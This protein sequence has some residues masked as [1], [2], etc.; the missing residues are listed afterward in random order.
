MRLRVQPA[1]IAIPEDNPFKFDRLNRQE[2]IEAL[3]T[4]LGN[5]EGPCVI[6][7]DAPW[8]AGK[9]TFIR[10][11]EQV[12]RNKDIPV[13]RVNAWQTDFSGNPFLAI[14][15]GIR[16]G[17]SK[18]HGTDEI[19]PVETF[20]HR[21]K[22]V[23]RWAAPGLAQ[24]LGGTI[25]FA[26]A[27]LGPLLGGLVRDVLSDQSK[28]EESVFEFRDSLRSLAFKLVENSDAK[29]LFIFID[30]L[31]RCRPTYAVELLE[32]DK[33]FFA[34]DNV[35][36]V[37]S[38]NLHQL[39]HSLKTVYGKGFDAAG[40]LGRFFDV[41]YRLPNPDKAGFI[42]DLI[43]A[44]NLSNYLAIA[45]KPHRELLEPKAVA[46]IMA[47]IFENSNLE[48][49]DID[50]AIRRLG[51]VFLSL[52]RIDMPSVLFAMVALI[53]RTI[54][55]ELYDQFK[56][57]RADDEQVVNSLLAGP[58]G[59]RL[60]H[61]TEAAWIQATTILAGLELAQA[62]GATGPVTNTPLF[63]RYRSTLTQGPTSNSESA[64]IQ[65]IMRDVHYVLRRGD[66]VS[67]DQSYDARGL[68]AI[69]A[70]KKV[71][72]VSSEFIGAF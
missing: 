18:Y 11:W 61:L 32:V 19:D 15:S 33:H 3:T 28:A 29:P 38:V 10:I 50:Q 2:N 43:D 27:T 47:R 39:V 41:D 1:E 69:E 5:I 31:D 12:L 8:G 44:S 22:E 21:A 45:N 57:G 54:D 67:P 60:S 62:E 71:D 70:F 37:L 17:L 14:S 26:G 59:L 55:R 63:N 49:R 36:F 66:L 53:L 42:E 51:L 30:E 58:G 6:A 13:V 35:V 24:G 23:L 40:Y 52:P 64:W 4:I 34:V 9:T 72:L 25:P 7:I 65:I 48:L 46:W 20:S 56:V 16:K 68:G